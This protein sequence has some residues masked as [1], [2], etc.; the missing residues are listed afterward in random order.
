MKI[1]LP[2]SVHD[3]ESEFWSN[4]DQC[5]FGSDAPDGAAVRG[6]VIDHDGLLTLKDA[7]TVA[8]SSSIRRQFTTA[9]AGGS[10]N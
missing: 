5:W 1:S 3:E 7:F 6:F 10:D 2:G 9:I 4:L 8:A